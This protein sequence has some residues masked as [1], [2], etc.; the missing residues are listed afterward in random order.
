MGMMLRR[1]G[2]FTGGIVLPDEKQATLDSPI[3]GCPW[4]VRTLRVPLAACGGAAATPV[5][6]AGESVAAG[7]KLAAA[8]DELGVDVFAPLAGRVAGVVSVPV[9]QAGE[10]VASPALELTD[11]SQP[12][13]IP[14]Q[15]PLFDWRHKSPQEIRLRLE[16]GGLTTC[17]PCPQSLVHYLATARRKNCRM[18]VANVLEQQPYV[19]S[20]H[21]L[22][23]EHGGEVVRGLAILAAALEA[24]DVLLVVDQRRTGDY[25]PLASAARTFDIARLAL[26]PKYPAG[27]DAILAKVLTGR[28]VPP[29]GGSLDIGVAIVN[30]STCFAA[31]RWVACQAPHTARAVTVSGPRASM[32]GNYWTPLGLLCRDLLQ[33]PLSPSFS[34]THGGPMI[35]SV[36]PIEA[37][38]TSATDAVLALEPAGPHVATPCIRCGWCTEHCPARLNVS[39]L[40]DMH[41]LG[42]VDRSVRA[43]VLACVECGVCSYICPARLPLSQRTKQLKHIILTL[44][45]KMPLFQPS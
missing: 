5:V 45:K 24:R 9:P 1:Y 28:E 37:V 41:E 31:H 8:S 17:R 26:P 15:S 38:V 16:G 35:G 42:H 27:H 13:P 23:V 2:T 43:G 30:A 32:P 12:E 6:Q 33:E 22:L 7:Q 36:C 44:R 10:F 39:A 29:G 18:L 20:D 34:L 40:N 3:G 19:T 14:V 11:L 21:R 4:P 25:R